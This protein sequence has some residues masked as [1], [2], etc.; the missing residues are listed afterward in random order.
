MIDDGC[1]DQGDPPRFDAMLSAA[2]DFF[3][4]CNQ[5]EWKLAHKYLDVTSL[6]G[7]LQDMNVEEMSFI[8]KQ[9]RCIGLCGWHFESDKST[10]VTYYFHCLTMRS[11]SIQL[12]FKKS[13]PSKIVNID[14]GCFP[15]QETLDF[16]PSCI[17]IDPNSELVPKYADE[18]A[19]WCA[20]MPNQLAVYD[21]SV[22][23]KS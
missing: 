12:T 17:H 13:H 5:F 14:D 7:A 18:L 8:M 6:G 16:H 10:E 11:N 3:A 2:L 23:R 22:P 9:K 19:E 15:L 21:P 20:I 4:Q 1:F